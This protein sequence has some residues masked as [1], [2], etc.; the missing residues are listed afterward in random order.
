MNE[1]TFTCNECK[2]TLPIINRSNKD[3]TLC[4]MC[5][6][7]Y[8]S[9]DDEDDFQC[10]ADC[11]LPDACSDFGCAIKSGLRPPPHLY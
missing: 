10:C 8:D 4:Y 11:D 9:D 3:K 2:H 1:K 6:I 7:N 5:D